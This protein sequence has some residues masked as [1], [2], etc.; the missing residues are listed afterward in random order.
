M[1]TVMV[2]V[3]DAVTVAGLNDAVAP[4][5]IPL[6]LNATVPLKPFVGVTFGANVV[7]APWTT[8][9]DVGVDV[10]P[11]LPCGAA[12]TTSVTVAVFTRLP[13]VPVMVRV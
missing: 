3:P 11:K 5:G 10:S 2:V 9:C 1:T 12:F 4:V 8:D 13:L 7:L 6:T